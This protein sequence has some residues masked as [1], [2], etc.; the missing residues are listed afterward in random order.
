[1][2]DTIKGNNDGENGENDSYTI[3]G[4]GSHIAR[5]TIVR[6]VK[7]GKHPNF[8]IYERNGVEYVRGKPDSKTRNNVND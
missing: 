8:G 5:R 4:R 3:P 6:E 1:M 7:D 2:A